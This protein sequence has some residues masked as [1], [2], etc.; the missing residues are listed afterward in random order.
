MT[1]KRKHGSRLDAAISSLAGG[2]AAFVLFAM[3]DDLLAR[4]FHAVG[5]ASFSPKFQPP[6]AFGLR[7]GLAV[8]AG[9]LVFAFIW[10]LMKALDRAPAAAAAKAADAVP[11]PEP[12]APRLRKADAH[13]DAP[14]R[15]PL[16]AGRDLGEP[17]ELDEPLELQPEQ[18]I[19]PS[20]EDAIEAK[21]EFVPQPDP[22][23]PV[24]DE[25][26][27][28]APVAAEPAPLPRFL[29]PQDD[30][31]QVEPAEAPVPEAPVAAAPDAPAEESIGSLMRRFETGLGRK[32]QALADRPALDPV[33]PPAPAQ[34]HSAPPVAEPAPAAVAAP[35]P[36]GHRLR[37]AI[38][39]LQKASA[40]R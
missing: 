9:L 34:I 39:D 12:E 23:P 27:P 36:V 33:P 14:A 30:A 16:L 28:L 31:P 2:S 24:A 1:M 19:A 13:P 10:S 3:P 5:L 25:P 40:S 7:L 21:E 22:L 18:A 20:D 6:F 17:I 35:A 32:K 11:L 15:R 8:A 26:K 4:T 38:A 29:V 37:S